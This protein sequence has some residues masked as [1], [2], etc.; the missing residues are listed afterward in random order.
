MDRVLITICAR[1]G[2]KGVLGKNFRKLDGKPLIYYTIKQALD[3]GKAAK[4][5]VSTDSKEIQDI[6]ISMGVEAPFLRPDNL[7]SD[8][9]PKLPAIKHALNTCEEMFNEDYGFVLDLD[10][11][12]P[13]RTTQ[14]LDNAFNLLKEKGWDQLLSATQAQK[15]PY[16]N[17]V[18]LSKEGSVT[19]CKQLDRLVARRQDAPNVYSLNASIYI[20]RD[21]FLREEKYKKKPFSE[22]SGL[23]IMNENSATDIDSLLDFSFVEFLIEKGIVTL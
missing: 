16:F 9:S 12:S 3:W 8:T 18:E 10:P 17:L 4:I 23:Y 2:S 20:Y 1:A 19:I 21:S 22:N 15:N 6:A 13:I 5:V 11:T 7:S 14:D